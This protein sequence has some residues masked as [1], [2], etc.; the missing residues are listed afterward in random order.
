MHSKQMYKMLENRLSDP[1]DEFSDEYKGKY[2]DD[3]RHKEQMG[4]ALTTGE[5][6]TQ[7]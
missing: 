2:G 6:L 7:R 5:C 1:G 3:E 4:C